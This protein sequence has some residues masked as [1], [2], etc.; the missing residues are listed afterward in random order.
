MSP[1]S[2][3]TQKVILVIDKRGLVGAPL[4]A[5]L[6]R[7]HF[8]ILVSNDNVKNKHV[9]CVRYGSQIPK[10]PNNVFSHI[11]II[12]PHENDLSH[13]LPI[14]AQKTKQ[15]NGQLFVIKNA[16]LMS[17][18]CMKECSKHTNAIK[19]LL[20]G[21]IYS[22]TI[23][24]SNRL[25]TLLKEAK[26]KGTL[27]LFDSGLNMVYPIRL[28]QIFLLTESLMYNGEQ[29]MYCL[30]PKKGISEITVGR[31]LHKKLPDIK[32]SL[33]AKKGTDTLQIPYACRETISNEETLETLEHISIEKVATENAEGNE[34][35]GMR[36]RKQLTYLRR[37][38]VVT[39][40]TVFFL[41]L[42]PFLFFFSGSVSL[43][44]STRQVE[45]GQFGSA[46]ANA[47]IASQS[48]SLV[49][50]TIEPIYVIGQT[51]GMGTQMQNMQ[52]Q[53]QIAE[54]SSGAVFNVSDGASH[55]FASAEREQQDQG[56]AEIRFAA[57]QTE[58][59]M[60]EKEMNF[61]PNVTREQVKV[62]LQGFSSL[63]SSLPSLLGF[64]Q[65]KTYLVLFQNSNELRPGG[66]FIG[67]YG[68]AKMQNASIK[69]FTAQDVYSLDGQLQGHVSPPVPLQKYL[70]VQ[71]WFLR[72]SNFSV[73]QN[74]NAA[75]ESY[76]YTLESGKTV[77]GVIL[78]DT[79]VLQ[80]LLDLTGPISVPE[81]NQ[82]ITSQNFFQL[83]EDHSE[84]NFT[85][86]SQQ[87]KTFLSAFSTALQQHLTDHPLSMKVLGEFF[88]EQVAGKHI[89]FWSNNQ[90]INKDLQYSL[91]DISQDNQEQSSGDFFGINEANLGLNKVNHYIQRSMAHTISLDENGS[92]THTATVTYKN[93]SMPQSSYGGDYKV[94]IRAIIPQDAILVGITING[95][96]Q[97]ISLTDSS[98]QPTYKGKTFLPANSLS[99]YPENVLGESSY[100]FFTTVPT[101]TTSVVSVTYT[102][103][104]KSAG[105][106]VYQLSLM[107]QPGTDADPV[108]IHVQT[109]H[110]SILRQ[111]AFSGVISSH[112]AVTQF[113]LRTD[114]TL[115][116]QFS[117]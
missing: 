40:L 44:S 45:A 20:Y 54:K 75:T 5:F 87:K 15:D 71:N 116:L 105:A 23:A 106:Q 70:G 41:C 34:E 65:T 47:K 53:I 111:D 93:T 24:F 98:N 30:F 104:Q 59:L 95:K 31:L 27:H 88:V 13:F 69:D 1:Q 57:Q 83:F 43:L 114:Q 64:S 22:E 79:F 84:K 110:N 49:S 109:A 4:A 7:N 3:N 99:V 86:G 29:G 52:Q 92:V 11:F 89:F 16:Y 17:P 94:F 28:S 56:L 10:I 48:F 12:D 18:S 113:N 2:V 66:G 50:A 62:A 67:S 35:Q 33:S 73:D 61:L 80:K 55:L 32:I 82:Q 38:L 36:Q 100:G 60:A 103:P 58:E 19:V 112:T 102:L 91:A 9:V 51:V 72:D 107:K 26:E 14:L 74:Q 81:Y 63:Q 85:P 96:E 97:P 76:F 6:S 21:D 117:R 90:F 46:A 68:I 115:R 37:T 77:D 108:V 25:H 42:F 78:V 39:G 8:V 101:Q